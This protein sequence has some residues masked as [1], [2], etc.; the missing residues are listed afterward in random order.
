MRDRA[1]EG[2]LG[3]WEASKNITKS[4]MQVQEFKYRQW[5][6]WIKE[7]RQITGVRNEEEEFKKVKRDFPSQRIKQR[8]VRKNRPD[9]ADEATIRNRFEVYRA[10]TEP[11]LKCFPPERVHRINADAPPVKVATM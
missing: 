11:M 8:G 9:D 1:K 5:E 10:E 3:F 6:D 4:N 2:S 7:G